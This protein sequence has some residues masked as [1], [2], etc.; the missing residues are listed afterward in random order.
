MKTN[1]P[2]PGSCLMPDHSIAILGGENDYLET[3]E[4][5]A[6]TS[7]Y[8]VRILGPICKLLQEEESGE[9]KASIRIDVSLDVIGATD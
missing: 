7:C 2:L 3:T 1:L 4:G 6:P 8:V 5:K 9:T